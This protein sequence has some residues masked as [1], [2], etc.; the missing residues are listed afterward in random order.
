MRVVLKPTT[1]KQDEILF[2]AVSPG[3]TSLAS[4]QDFVAAETASEV[5]GR[6][7]AR[8]AQPTAIWSRLLAGKTA[9]VRPEIGETDEGLRGGASRRDLETMFQLIYLTFTQPRADP[10]AF[11]AITGQLTATL[12]NRQ[13]LPEAAFDD[14]LEA[15]LTQDHLRARPLSTGARRR[16]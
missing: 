8:Q 6:R 11:R 7:R 13:A 10:E 3:G 2:R 14:A 4:D 1:F 9:W 16:R 5:I 15:A 12:A